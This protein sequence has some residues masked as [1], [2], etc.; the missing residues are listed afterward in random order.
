MALILTDILVGTVWILFVFTNSCVE[1]FDCRMLAL[2]L[3]R[4][5]QPSEHAPDSY[6]VPS[7]DELL[8]EAVDLHKELT[9]KSEPIVDT[10]EQ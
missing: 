4:R 3:Q 2:V 6:M 7:P 9:G 8:K 10:D 5:R 1:I